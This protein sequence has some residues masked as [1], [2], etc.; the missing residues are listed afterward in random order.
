M[1]RRTGEYAPP[2]EDGSA[3]SPA[4]DDGDANGHDEEEEVVESVGG[5]DAMEEVPDRAPRYT[6]ARTRSRR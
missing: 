5:A 4:H 6:A 3:P 2:A 1:P